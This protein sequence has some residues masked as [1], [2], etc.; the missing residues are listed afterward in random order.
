MANPIPSGFHTITPHLIIKGAS[1]AIE[2]YK[3]AF[4]AVEKVRMPFPSP[5]GTMKLGHAEL[6]IGD[7]KLFLADEFPQQGGFGP[8]GPSPVAI[9][10]YVADTDAVFATA[11]EAGAK[12]IMPPADMFWGDRYSKLVDPFGHT[13]DIATHIEDIT[14]EQMKERMAAMMGGPPTQS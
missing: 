8:T 9:H 2:F 10:L 3:K 1:E 7:S 14:P 4:G 12:P 6:E 13:W 11:V 5:D